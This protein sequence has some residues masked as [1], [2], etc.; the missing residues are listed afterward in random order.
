MNN[1]EIVEVIQQK[2]SKIQLM[3]NL[4]NLATF[5]RSI[6][7]QEDKTIVRL[8]LPFYC[9]DL[10]R[11]LQ[12]LVIP[13]VDFIIEHKIYAHGKSNK[14]K[15]L[16]NIKNII[17]IASGKGGVGKSTIATN[18]T[19]A[20]HKLGAKVG[21]L[22]ADIYGPSLPHMLNTTHI[23]PVI[24]D[25]K[26]IEPIMAFGI[27]TI[28]IGNL[29]DQS[30]AAIWRG[31]M[32]SSALQ[33]LIFQTNWPKLEYLIID[34]PPGTGDI[35]LT[36]AQKIPVTGAVIVTTPQ[37]VATID[38][39]KAV[40]MFNKVDIDILGIVSNMSYFVCDNCDKKHLIFNEQ[41]TREINSKFNQEILAQLPLIPN[42]AHQSDLGNPYMAADNI[43]APLYQEL[44][45]LASKISYKLSLLPKIM[46]LPTTVVTK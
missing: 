3:D 8:Q 27:P 37:D 16:P 5:I 42:I 46:Q 2:L 26:L 30:A 11:V 4:V 36:M 40:A 10:A 21:L 15:L 18:L 13:K 39:I 7:T 12:E 25:N 1:Q 38:A 32:V 20:L 33:Q 19:L 31:P 17:I 22:D 45:A 43:N 6:E 23:Q 35:Q 29:I 41:N 14:I 24:T 28:S 34:L 9:Y 44:M